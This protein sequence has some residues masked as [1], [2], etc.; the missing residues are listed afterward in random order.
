MVLV[1]IATMYH[2]VVSV[3]CRLTEETRETPEVE[4]SASE[5]PSSQHEVNSRSS[6]KPLTNNY[7]VSHQV[8]EEESTPSPYS[9]GAQKPN[10]NGN[11]TNE[12]GASAEARPTSSSTEGKAGKGIPQALTVHEKLVK[13]SLRFDLVALILMLTVFLISSGAIFGSTG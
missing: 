4:S 11:S 12:N 13:Y 1:T 5:R 9:D 10:G 7:L 6:V 3:A 8:S 2:A